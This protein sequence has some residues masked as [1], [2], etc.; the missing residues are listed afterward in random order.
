[1]SENEK[2]LLPKTKINLSAYTK[3]NI[4]N[5]DNSD[6][7]IFEVNH[8]YEGD[9][10]IICIFNN[11]YYVNSYISLEIEKG[12]N[13][14]FF[15]EEYYYSSE[16]KKNYL[17]LSSN[18]NI[19][20]IDYSLYIPRNYS[21]I[22]YFNNDK[23]IFI[24]MDSFLENTKIKFCENKIIN[25]YKFQFNF[26]TEKNLNYIFYKYGS[27][28]LFMRTNSLSF[29][30]KFN[31]TYLFG[32]KEK[33]YLYIKKYNGNMNFYKNKNELDIFTDLEQ[34]QKFPKTYEDS[35]KYIIINNNLLIIDGYQLFSFFM[36][37]NCLFDFFFQKVKDLDYININPNM[38]EF[39]NLVKLL[40]KDKNYIL[41]FNVDHIIKLDNNFLDAKV[42]FI[43]E[44][45]KEF[46]LS[47]SNRVI[48]D[49]KGYNIKVSSNQ[50]ALIY[51]YQRMQN[52]KSGEGIVIFDKTQE[53][54]N[55]K[56][57]I[58]TLNQK[59]KSLYIVKDF[60]FEGYYPM[61][62]KKSWISIPSNINENITIYIDNI[63][64]QSDYELYE[65]EGERYI[66][67]IFDSFENGLPIFNSNDYNINNIA[68]IDNLMAPK[69]KYNFE[70]IPPNSKGS[71][72]L[73]SYNK[74]K[75]K[76]QLKKCQNKNNQMLNLTIVSLNNFYRRYN[77][78]DDNFNDFEIRLSD[79]E[80][81]SHTFESDSE[82]LFIYSFYSTSEIDSFQRKN[83]LS[84]I[85]I[86]EIEN[87]I[88]QIM[89][90]SAYEKN[91]EQ[92]YII[93]GIKNEINDMDS[94][95]DECSL[96]KL[97]NSNSSSIIVKSIFED[98]N[99]KIIGTKVNISEL[100]IN[101]NSELII[102][103]ICYSIFTEK[104]MLFYTPK[105]FKFEKDEKPILINFYEDVNFN[106]FSKNFFKFEYKNEFNDIQSLYLSA[107]YSEELILIFIGPNETQTIEL[108]RFTRQIKLSL[109]DSGTYYI[110]LL[111]KGKE[112]GYYDNYEGT[113]YLFIPG[114]IIDTIDLT[115][116]IYYNNMEFFFFNKENPSIIK[117]EGIKEDIYVFFDFS[118]GNNFLSYQPYPSPFEICDQNNQCERNITEFKFIKGNTYSIYINL[119][120]IG[121]NNFYYPSYLFFPIFKETFIQNDVGYY[122][123]SEPK[124]FLFDLKNSGTLNILFLKGNK[125]YRTF[126][127]NKIT[128]E[129][130]NN[131][132][133]SNNYDFRFPFTQLNYSSGNDYVLLI[134]IPLINKQYI[135]KI[136]ISNNFI[137]EYDLKNHILPAGQSEIIYSN[138]TEIEVFNN[139]NLNSIKLEKK[140][141]FYNNE[142]E[143]EEKN[144]YL[145]IYNVLT[146][147][148]SPIKN[149]KYLL[150]IELNDN[151]DYVIQNFFSFS[152]YIEKYTKDINISIKNY[153]PKYAFF[154]AMNNDLLN[155]FLSGQLDIILPPPYY[156]YKFILY[157]YLP[158]N[159]RINTD[160]NDFYEY[161]NFYLINLKKK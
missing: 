4:N 26:L 86:N 153:L 132:N 25:N 57:N 134:P 116:K 83:D 35:D 84:I 91:Q 159:F 92:Y 156:M 55:L 109:K 61:L 104:L 69:S 148:L 121:Y 1:M 106:I 53:R 114:N 103:I 125:L 97:M 74:N 31:I 67:Y 27:D 81:L 107:E 3:M 100:N 73:N 62:N 160:I 63:F 58:T 56:F 129:Q 123:L 23:N 5:K 39:N 70:I 46:I 152:I 124:I 28:S 108:E 79:Y 161:M 131:L 154:G 8:D 150:P 34:Y 78:K 66:I 112:S 90:N 89:F 10:N 94:F 49:L 68:Y 146:T 15:V 21:N 12:K 50:N 80:I 137:S 60:C 113:L 38:F 138:R 75:V 151:N 105:E 17:V 11:Y 144:N 102:S 45:G 64:D 32:I 120:D 41:N 52:Y 110:K 42:I 43:D 7:I 6:Y 48:K 133:Y 87:N 139:L 147:Y 98:S 9:I 2:K 40:N 30:Y 95:S 16:A 157:D 101:K 145:S 85:F 77:I 59:T 142:D 20:I 119:V 19:Q 72:I 29:D 117:V 76:Y 13:A 14:G 36:D 118:V 51:F 37:Y 54:K 143:Y 24:Y 65:N 22:L 99:N 141:N 88:L 128:L 140:L 158:S 130:L 47:K 93:V 126:S 135:S 115:K 136:S 18:E 111:L 127:Q 149:M 96:T 44:E 82:L 71:L 155:I 33:Y 122:S